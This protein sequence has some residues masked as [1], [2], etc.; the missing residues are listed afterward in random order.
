MNNNMET[1]IISW[2]SLVHKNNER[3]KDDGED[4]YLL[5]WLDGT[6]NVTEFYY[7]SE[8]DDEFYGNRIHHVSLEDIGGWISCR[9]L[10]D[11]VK[12]IESL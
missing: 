11:F 8:K 12:F 2:Q 3:P 6:L 7:W 9:E 4:T 10:N 5:L 1:S